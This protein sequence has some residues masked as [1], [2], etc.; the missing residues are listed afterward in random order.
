MD[1]IKAF[2]EDGELLDNHI[3]AQELERRTTKFL[4]HREKLLMKS[5]TKTDM[6]P[7]LQCHCP[8]EAGLALLEIH[9][10]VGGNRTGLELRYTKLSG[11]D[12]IGQQCYRTQ[13]NW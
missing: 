12:T 4:I 13:E 9:E 5:I 2:L 1:P 10:E 3:E 6:H 7:F 8:D 11:K